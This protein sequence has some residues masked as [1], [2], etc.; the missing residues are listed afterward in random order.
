MH[1]RVAVKICGTLETVQYS[2]IGVRKRDQEKLNKI[3]A[4]RE[5]LENILIRI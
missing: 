1:V 2:T 4:L 5:N 3:N